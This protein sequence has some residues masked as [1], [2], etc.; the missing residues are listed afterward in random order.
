[1]KKILSL[2]LVLTMV[3]SLCACGNT[4]ETAVKPEQNTDDVTEYLKENPPV[5]QIANPWSDCT[6]IEEAEDADGIAS[7]QSTCEREI[8]DAI[9]GLDGRK[10][11]KTDVKHGV[12]IHRGK[13]ILR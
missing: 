1:M 4:N 12:Y 10:V 9:Y 2:C 8:S 13:K 11:E 7:P 3:L 6:T 5:M